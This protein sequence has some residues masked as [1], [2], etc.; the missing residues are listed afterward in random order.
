MLASLLIQVC[1]GKAWLNRPIYLP[2]GSLPSQGK[3]PH[4]GEVLE[5][6]LV[7]IARDR[8][9]DPQ[10]VF[11]MAPSRGGGGWKTFG[12]TTRHAFG[13]RRLPPWL[14]AGAQA[15]F[16]PQRGNV[17]KHQWCCGEGGEIINSLVAYLA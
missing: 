15:S 4:E 5:M 6:Y 17:L 3:S 9:G 7:C 16:F 2:P 12:S 11:T 10:P 13:Q 1:T 14:R 8:A